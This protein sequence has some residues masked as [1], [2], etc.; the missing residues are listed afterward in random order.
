MPVEI[1]G[2]PAGRVDVK[3]FQ[4]PG[5]VIVQTCPECNHVRRRDYGGDSYL[6]FPPM[7]ERF[8][9]PCW[10][11]ECDHEWTVPVILSVGLVVLR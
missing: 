7:N 8:A 5:I 10:C 1:E 6:G 9:L 2:T 3:R 4:L 11:P